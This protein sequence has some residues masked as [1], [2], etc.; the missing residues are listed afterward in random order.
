M[1]LKSNLF[2]LSFPVQK[3][4]F[5]NANK[6]PSAKDHA[7]FLPKIKHE[8]ARILHFKC[9]STLSFYH[10]KIYLP[11]KRAEWAWIVFPV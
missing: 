9:L 2:L 8:M 4:V 3:D 7:V 11:E 5:L 10:V 1:L 6:F